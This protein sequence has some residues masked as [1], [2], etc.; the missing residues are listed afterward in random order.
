MRR[1][2]VLS[3]FCLS[4]SCANPQVILLPAFRRVEQVPRAA[5]RLPADCRFSRVAITHSSNVSDMNPEDL[6]LSTK[7]AELMRRELL[8]VGATVTEQPDEA[9]WSLMVMA[10][11]DPRHHE[12]YVF[13]ASIGLRE[14]HEGRDPGITTYRSSDS[15]A[16]PT[17]YTGLGFGPGYT[18]MPTVRAFVDRADAALLPAARRLCEHDERE[19]RRE[20][21]LQARLPRPL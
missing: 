14:L 5:E 11:S 8:R 1:F 18:L 13:S 15:R 6:A 9:Y 7:V 17:H 19:A 21:E 16:V 10:A 12:G 2:V 4:L 20:A 3:V